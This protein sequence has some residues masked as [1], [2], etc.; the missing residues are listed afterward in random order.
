TV[1]RRTSAPA[2]GIL[3]PRA[4]A[5]RRGFDGT[6]AAGPDQNGQGKSAGRRGGIDPRGGRPD[7]APGIA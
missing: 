4:A 6:G 7:D 5:G 3:P 1:P 2:T